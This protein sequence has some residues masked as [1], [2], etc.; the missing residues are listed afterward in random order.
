[1][2]ANK[3]FLNKIICK[4]CSSENF[5]EAYKCSSCSNVLRAKVPNINFWSVIYLLIFDT[6][7]AFKQILYA[8][9]K[10]FLLPL[11]ILLNIKLTSLIFVLGSVYD[12]EIS[13]NLFWIALFTLT[14]V[15]CIILFFYLEFIRGVIN[16]ISMQNLFRKNYFA[17]IGYAS[18]IFSMSIFLLL[19]IE[20]VLFGPFLFSGNPSP[21]AIKPIPAYM[22][23]GLEIFVFTLFL[24]F[25]FIGFKIYSQSFRI[26]IILTVSVISIIP[27]LFFL[28]KYIFSIIRMV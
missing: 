21:F 5:F 1:M 27:I 10:N 24:I 25:T 18:S 7:N 17:I 8:D 6:E 9:N 12:L 22:L 14:V 3:I 15:L 11:F 2:K 20:L 13:F 16:K 28:S 23:A 26:S 4:S 19:T